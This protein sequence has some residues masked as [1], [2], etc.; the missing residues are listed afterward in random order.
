LHADGRSVPTPHLDGKHVVFGRVRSNRGLVR[1]IENIPVTN[2]RPNEPVVIA[3]AGV[4]SPEEVAKQEEERKAAAQ[5]S[6]EED[7]WEVSKHPIS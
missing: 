4:L 6:G 3:A 7:V 2:D 1:R 5:N